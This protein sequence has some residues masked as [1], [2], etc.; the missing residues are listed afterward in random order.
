MVLSASSWW[1][2]VMEPRCKETS[3]CAVLPVPP[4]ACASLVAPCPPS[5]LW[6]S[7]SMISASS[8]T[9]P[10][11]PSPSLLSSLSLLACL[12]PPELASTPVLALDAAW[13]LP[14][15]KPVSYPPPCLVRGASLHWS[16]HRERER[17][18]REREKREREER[19][20]ERE[21][22]ERERRERES[23]L[24]ARPYDRKLE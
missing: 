23:P 20:R 5:P 18:R 14:A 17:E 11:L 9:S 12:A 2:T 19:E 15:P 13:P 21:R 1:Q 10:P 6:V 8:H 7:M 22:R 16:K 24:P 3:R 4:E